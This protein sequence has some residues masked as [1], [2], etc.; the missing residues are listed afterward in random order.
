MPVSIP[1]D[2]CQGNVLPAG[3]RQ[4]VL[5]FL[6]HVALGYAFAQTNNCHAY[7]EVMDASELPKIAEVVDEA[8]ASVSN[9]VMFRDALNSLKGTGTVIHSNFSSTALVLSFWQ[10]SVWCF[11]IRT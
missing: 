7:F 6:T 4:A 2:L 1:Q 10:V 11:P 8:V 3:R 9:P 5:P